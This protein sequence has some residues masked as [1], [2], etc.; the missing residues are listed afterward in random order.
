[1]ELSGAFYQWNIN[2]LKA[3]H[4][5]EMDHFTSL[6]ILVYS[7]R[8][9]RGDDRFCWIPYKRRLFDVRSY[10]KVLVLHDITHFH[11]RSIW[12]NNAL[13][14][15]QVLFGILFSAA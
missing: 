7:I 10:Y 13:V 1:V 15:S 9:R 12:R 4:D 2:F 3:T 14:R 6:F 8:V 5:W 11:W